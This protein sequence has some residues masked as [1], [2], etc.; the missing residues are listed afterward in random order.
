MSKNFKVVPISELRIRL[1]KIK[2]QVQLGQQRIVVTHYGETVGFLLP[3]SDLAPDCGV[4]I[5]KSVEMPLTRFREELTETWELLEA[6]VDCVYLTFH[7][8]RIMAF[9]N[10]RLSPH[11][12]IPVFDYSG[13]VLL[14]ADD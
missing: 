13:K 7:T 2:R 11:L 12:S 10:R 6:N 4:P 8:R 9:V 1:T 3:L 14:V 5:Q